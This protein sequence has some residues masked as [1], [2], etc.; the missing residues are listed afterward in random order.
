M[1]FE[2]KIKTKNLILGAFLGLFILTL[3]FV[4]QAQAN[5]NID[6]E[7]S[8]VKIA[9]P[10]II[11]SGQPVK[12]FVTVRADNGAAFE[13]AERFQAKICAGGNGGVIA[14]K[15]FDGDGPCIVGRQ[16]FLADGGA[17]DAQVIRKEANQAFLSIDIAASQNRFGDSDIGFAV[18][19]KAV[20]PLNNA[21]D[22]NFVG[23]S[24]TYPV[25]V[26]ATPDDQDE[27]EDQNNI[28]LTVT[29]Q[30]AGN[31]FNYTARI[32][33]TAINPATCACTLKWFYGRLGSRVEATGDANKNP[34]EFVVEKD[35]VTVQYRLNSEPGKF[36]EASALGK[37]TEEQ[38]A[39]PGDGD[40]NPI[41]GVIAFII[42]TI[43]NLIIT[44]VG[45]ITTVLLVPIMRSLLAI[46][47]HDAQFASIIVSG[48]VIVR[49][50]ANI[51]F[52]LALILISLA[53]LFQVEKYNYKHLLVQVVFMALLVNFSL[54]IARAI[55]G[56]AD[57]I[58]AQFIPFGNPDVINNL[59]HHLIVK[60][61]INSYSFTEV[62]NGTFSM[63]V[64]PMF[65][66]IFALGAFAAFAAIT[67]FLL[68]RVVAIMLLLVTSPVAYVG[69]IFG[70]GQA[71]SISTRWWSEFL[72]YAFFTPILAFFLKLCALIAIQ[73]A[74]LGPAVL[75]VYPESSLPMFA[76][77]V[78]NNLSN[79]LIIA[80]LFAGLHFAKS[81]H[82]AF[83]DQIL[84]RAKKFAGAPARW[85]GQGVMY[86]AGAAKD[87]AV[88]KKQDA[89]EQLAKST[90]P[91][92]K[93]FAAR[94]AFRVIN[95]K[96]AFEAYSQRVK[97]KNENAAEK[98]KAAARDLT[99]FASSRGTVK[100]RH[101]E[102]EQEKQDAKIKSEYATKTWEELQEAFGDIKKSS[103][104]KTPEGQRRLRMIMESAIETGKF[105][106]LVT[107]HPEG[108]GFTIDLKDQYFRD[109]L[110]LTDPDNKRFLNNI[111]DLGKKEHK[112]AYIDQDK[113]DESTIQDRI[114][115]MVAH[116]N[117]MSEADIE[118][119]NLEGL[120]FD[121]ESNKVRT[122]VAKRLST[123]GVTKIPIK[124]A[125]QFGV[126][127]ITADGK[128]VHTDV[129][130][131]N[132]FNQLK[133]D[134]GDIALK[135]YNAAAGVN[136][137]N[138]LYWQKDIPDGIV[139]TAVPPGVEVHKAGA[140]IG[141]KL[142]DERNKEQAAQEKIVK[143]YGE[144]LEINKQ[145]DKKQAAEHSEALEMNKNFDKSQ[146]EALRAANEKIAKDQSEALKMNKEF[147]E[148][149][150]R[151]DEDARRGPPK[152][153]FDDNNPP[154]GV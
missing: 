87:Y 84:D 114:E 141:K 66:L 102:R 36:Y 82:V 69:R 109:N 124:L 81:Q 127:E 96:T 95:P 56:I 11:I 83:G 120:G 29:R 20:V 139:K 71:S 100:T 32:N 27:K 113:M 86:G 53:T 118:K 14:I 38:T 77:F 15:E 52:M 54:V 39:S 6:L 89:T 64:E 119:I 128:P 2:I 21:F 104:A 106:Q 122:A 12:V 72:K 153:F 125:K 8:D 63:V 145:F 123:L 144:A 16:V 149:Q 78:Y 101:L 90:A 28:G 13:L 97:E 60:A 43:V 37:E 61:N 116:V 1:N 34:A 4:P 59:A 58:Q 134:H 26:L 22:H 110:D 7:V 74:A 18:A 103:F 76:Q 41:I 80:C 19:I 85:A 40:G 99:T 55:L 3:G 50:I 105:R 49:N 23:V 129:D 45:Q 75:K 9:D 111:S 150:R 67:A 57:T 152:S 35:V 70:A 17:G 44:V 142:T 135:A 136:D 92:I 42:G 143:E 107:G 126:P 154:S 62:L 130:T 31:S 79:V 47:V 115:K 138:S 140:A 30:Q 148:E 25:T 112:I 46:Q 33:G 146:A 88:R 24:E 121:A 10:G 65:H 68:I 93:G 131:E 132:F 94:S 108:D 5:H 51:F 147:D 117:T 137:P 91:G 98:S 151:K 48:W 133:I 73:T